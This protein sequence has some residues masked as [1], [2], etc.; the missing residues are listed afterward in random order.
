M[1]RVDVAYSLIFDEVESKI[2]MVKNNKYN[3]W[4]LPGGAVEVG[5]TL[6]M[7][8]V[9]E[10]K[11]ETGFTVEVGDI[12]SVNEAFME[13]DGH[14]ALFVTFRAKAVGGELAIQDTDASVGISEVKWIDLDAA[15]ELMPYHKNGLKVMLE[16]SI[17]YT[18]QGVKK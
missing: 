2:L 12:V 13:A 17:P 6:E 5:E 14:H 3:N 10:A 16:S 7:A 9:R 18:F 4:T 15:A 1:K 8:A 11:E